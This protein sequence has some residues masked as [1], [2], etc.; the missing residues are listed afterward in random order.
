MVRMTS[1]AQRVRAEQKWRDARKGFFI[2]VGALA[3]VAIAI[4]AVF[5]S[6]HPVAWSIGAL[7]AWVV[8]VFAI[9]GAFLPGDD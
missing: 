5:G 7:I 3:V 9:G 6:A 8:G 2:T 4:V 1:N